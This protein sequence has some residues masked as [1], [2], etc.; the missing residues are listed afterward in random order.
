[1]NVWF[2]GSETGPAI[3]DV[4][5]GDKVPSGKLSV[6][7][8]QTTGQEPLYYNHMNTGRPVKTGADR[9]YKYQSNYMDVRNDAL[10]PFG[11]GLSYTRFEYS[12]VRLSSSTLSEGGK[13]TASVVVRNTGNYDADEVVQL[14]IRDIES[15]CVRPVKELKGFRRI[16]LAKG[17]SKEV[18][19]DLTADLLKYYDYDCRLVLEPGKFEIMIGSSSEAV[20]KAELVAK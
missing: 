10:Y 12:D 5:F 7:M 19:F 4:L 17:E 16:H 15:E 6:S 14:Y 3:C 8:P 9:Y 20:K 2:G 13:I 18:T 11:Y 1:M